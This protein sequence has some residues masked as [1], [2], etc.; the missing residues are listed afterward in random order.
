MDLKGVANSIGDKIGDVSQRVIQFLSN[1]GV[2]TSAT[3]GKFITLAVIFGLI[4]LFAK[5]VKKPAK[6]IAIIF[7]ALAGVTILFSIGL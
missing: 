4:W 5:L 2:N 1:E 6:W 7:L 3:T